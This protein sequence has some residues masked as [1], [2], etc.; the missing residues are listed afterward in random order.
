MESQCFIPKTSLEMCSHSSSKGKILFFRLISLI[1]APLMPAFYFGQSCLLSA[2]SICFEK[3][4]SNWEFC[5]QSQSSTLQRYR[6]KT[7]SG[8]KNTEESTPS[9]E[10]LQQSFKA[11]N[12]ILGILVIIVISRRYSINFIM[13]LQISA[14]TNFNQTIIK[15]KNKS[16][17]T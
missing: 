17:L 6:K 10:S 11:S 4:T 16:F 14:K 7:F 12:M 13:F 9:S 5:G 3:T 8:L 1:F 2:T 15:N